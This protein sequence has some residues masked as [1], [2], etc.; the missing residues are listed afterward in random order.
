MR[1]AWQFKTYAVVTAK[2]AIVR[3]IEGFS[4]APMLFRSKWEAAKTAQA[5][6]LGSEVIKVDVSLKRRFR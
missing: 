6:G 4:L 5:V 2:G 1:K 3:H